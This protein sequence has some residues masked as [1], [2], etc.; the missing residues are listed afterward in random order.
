M[1]R[2]G[3]IWK[4][5]RTVSTLNTAVLPLLIVYLHPSSVVRVGWEPGA[6]ANNSFMVL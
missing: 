2:T 6:T 4:G 3:C 1:G 5:E